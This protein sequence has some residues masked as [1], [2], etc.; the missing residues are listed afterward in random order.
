MADI[1]PFRALRYRNDL[2]LAQLLT[3]PYDKIT[4]S[5]QEAYYQRSP[6]NLIRFELGKVEAGDNALQNVYSRAS[7][8]LSELIQ[9]GVLHGDGEPSIYAYA[10]RFRH[11]LAQE[12]WIERRCFI[13]LGAVSPYEE[14]IVYRHEQTLSKPKADRM[15][16]LKATR[17][18]SGLIFML[19]E[20]EQLSVEKMIW[21]SL[22]GKR[23]DATV[24]DELGVENSLW[25][26]DD[27]A[28]IAAVQDAMKTKRLII[29]DGH[30]R[31]ETSLRYKQ[32]QGA[33]AGP[34]PFDY[35]QMGFVS[36]QSAGLLVLPT[37]RVVFGL[38]SIGGIVEQL[39]CVFE[40]R[41]LGPR[42]PEMLTKLLAEEGQGRFA[43][44]MA[45]GSDTFLLT[46]SPEE[47]A[48]Q[49]P[50]LTE[51]ERRL[52]VTLLHQLILHEQL[53]LSEESVREQRNIRYYRSAAEAL[54][55]VQQGANFAFLL[56]PVSMEVMRDLSYA[57]R[58]MPQKS[59]DF[60]PK[61]LSG[62]TLYDLDR[63]YSAARNVVNP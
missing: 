28:V 15:D 61:L 27:L 18:H 33:S 40:T 16:L 20:D 5:M 62:L 6:H 49:L 51:I 26:V 39:K 19:Y 25:R 43:T 12:T 63:G 41:K 45:A 44:V 32:E 14:G 4:P 10:Q 42:D 23:A 22:S 46:L 17:T 58:V 34:N 8:F 29:A 13:A 38:D 37:H 24:V 9:S 59:T 47:A 2:D 53:G 60:Y 52:D 55:D 50:N 56:N 1:R 57:G 11:P 7:Q 21:N 35:T 48:K 31:Y 54:K 30:H 3:Q 36:I